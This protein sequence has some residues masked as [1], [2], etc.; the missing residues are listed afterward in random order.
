M[1]SGLPKAVEGIVNGIE[2]DADAG[3]FLELGGQL[4]AYFVGDDLDNQI[5]GFA[6]NPHQIG[7]ILYVFGDRP[8]RDPQTQQE[9]WE[10]HVVVGE[11]GEQSDIGRRLK[12][13]WPRARK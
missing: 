9:V 7:A 10:N 8:G 6:V 1:N 2:G 13:A 4:A 11:V 5:W 12:R 3:V